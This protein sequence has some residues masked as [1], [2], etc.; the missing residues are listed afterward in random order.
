VALLLVLGVGPA[1]AHRSRP[2]S[3]D[4]AKATLLMRAFDGEQKGS[5]L[6]RTEPFLSSWQPAGI[7]VCLIHEPAA[8]DLV[9]HSGTQ[10]LP[11]ALDS[12][13]VVGCDRSFPA[14]PAVF[15]FTPAN[16]EHF[17][18]LAGRLT[19]GVDEKIWSLAFLVDADGIPFGIGG[20]GCPESCDGADWK[21]RSVARGQRGD[22]ADLAGYAVDFI[23]LVVRNS[24]WRIE[25]PVPESWCQPG[26]CA[27]YVLHRE[28]DSVWE[29]YGHPNRG[30]GSDGSTPRAPEPGDH[31]R[32]EPGRGDRVPFGGDRPGR[33]HTPQ[34][35][36]AGRWG[37]WAPGDQLGRE[38]L[39]A[40]RPAL[41]PSRYG[42]ELGIAARMASLF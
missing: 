38:P 19:N 36:P 13:N 15:D 20:G 8:L 10:P 42:P 12:T 33:R 4:P 1:D 16:S 22:V 6:I 5:T 9:D 37:L 24:S 11:A 27:G 17:D 14:G 30:P 21:P 29:I 3:G 35:D 7:S 39:T 23:R 2:G 40:L 34:W 32:D 25:Q 41:R 28:L 31:H 26:P 18:A